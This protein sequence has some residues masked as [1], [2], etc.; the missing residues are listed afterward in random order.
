MKTIGIIGGIGPESTVEYYRSI[1]S[2]YRSRTS[3]GS[4]P[5][6]I[7]NS[8]NLTRMLAFVES[9]QLGNLT[10]VLTDEVAKLANAG[11]EFGVLAS[12]TPHIIFD[13]L[14]E[15]SSIPLL[16]IVEETARKAKRLGLTR[17][18]LFG[19]KFTMQNLFYQKVLSMHEVQTIVPNLDEQEYIHTKYMSELV[20]GVFLEETKKRLLRIATA[21]KARDNIQ[22]LILGG[23]ELPLILSKDSE[24]GIPYLNT[25][26]IH[27][28]GII[29]YLFG[30]SHE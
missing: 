4:Y 8:I 7:I 6:I 20:P 26:K 14:R 29:D 15:D 18:G 1:I 17:V 11:A 5:Q 25:T 27:V 22:G 10:R 28:E 13:E 21:M 19:T 23:T 12:N 24:I 30:G 9:K 2:S 16:S 3:D